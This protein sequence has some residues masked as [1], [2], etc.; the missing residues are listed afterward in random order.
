MKKIY[1][2]LLCLFEIGVYAQVNI[3]KNPADYQPH[4]DAILEVKSTSPATAVLLP[5]VPQISSAA[6]PDGDEVFKG[7]IVYSKNNA[8]I[9]E[10]DGTNW[11]SVFDYVVE[12]KPQYLAHFS[13]PSNLKL[14]CTGGWLPPYGC[15]DDDI[16][17]LSNSGPSDFMGSQIHLSIAS[18]IITVNE[19]GLYRI[20]YRSYASFDGLNTDE[21][22]LRLQ[23]ANAAAPGT[24]ATI[25]YKSFVDANDDLGYSPV[26]NG[27]I[28]TQVNAG[29]R[30]RL[31]GFMRSGL[32]PFITSSTTFQNSNGYGVGEVIFEKILL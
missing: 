12:T 10:H 31:Q 27:S 22:Q 16:L 9:Y 19:T 23:K 28:V 4:P 29:D 5:T 3:S 25:D 14:E 11:R 18:N 17:P 7:A 15:T 20:T 26:F 6:D 13:R 2:I 1:I 21:I 30:F 8:S 24:F 32:S